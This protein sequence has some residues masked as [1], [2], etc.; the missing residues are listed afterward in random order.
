MKAI[1]FRTEEI[2]GCL[3]VFP[4]HSCRPISLYYCEDPSRKLFA[5]ETFGCCPLEN[6]KAIIKISWHEHKL[7]KID[8]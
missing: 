6:T 5:P 3:F 4:A 2:D 7:L 8:L 1:L